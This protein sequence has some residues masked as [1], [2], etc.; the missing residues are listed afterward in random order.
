MTID[1]EAKDLLVGSSVSKYSSLIKWTYQPGLT[2]SIYP[3]ELY[4]Y[5]L[6]D[7]NWVVQLNSNE[8]IYSCFDDCLRACFKKVEEYSPNT[9]AKH[10]LAN[11]EYGKFLANHEYNK[12]ITEL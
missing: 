12:I 10:M 5:Q 2:N 1:E 7:D 4:I 6:N 9:V 8:E 11:D 3:K